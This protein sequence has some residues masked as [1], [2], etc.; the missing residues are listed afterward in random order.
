MAKTA[1]KRKPAIDPP[2]SGLVIHDVDQ[3]S[4]E[5]F[6]ARLGVVTASNFAT[7]MADGKDGGP[8]LTR[9]KLL[10]KLAGEQMTGEPAEETFRSIAMDRGRSLEDEAR[11]SYCKRKNVEPRRVGFGTNFNGLK[12]CGASP[13]SLLG[14]DGGLE[15]KTARADILIPM[16][17]LPARMPPEHRCQV[18]GN[19]LVFERDW[20]DLTIYCHRSMPAM[21]VRIYRD[22]AFIKQ[23]SEQIERFN[24]ELN[25]LVASLKKMG[26]AG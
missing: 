1:V 16:L 18:Q 8:S 12:F 4:D 15:I 11:T 13:D 24:W 10:H 20:W 3:G 2:P 6:Q 25:N 21:D 14:F 5:W 26:A 17:K 19:M 9:T 23:L 7:V 22:D